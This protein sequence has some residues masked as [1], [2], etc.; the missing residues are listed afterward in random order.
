MKRLKVGIIGCGEV[1]Q[2]MH[3]PALTALPELFEVTAICDVSPGVLAGVGD[4]WRIAGRYTEHEALLAESGVDAV[5]I[6][7]P[8]VF[9]AEVAAAAMQAGKHV[10]IEKPMC[11]TL[12]EADTLIAAR[13][14]YGVVAQVGYMRRYDSGFLA[15]SEQVRAIGSV[16]MARIR[17]VIGRNA[18]IVNATSD[19]VRASD[20][21]EGS[22]QRLQARQREAVTAAI[23]PVSND[24]AATYVR[25][26]GL[27]SHD[28]SAMREMLGRP[29]GLFY[30]VARHS[31][32]ALSAAF[33]YGSFVC[34]MEIG[35]DEIARMDSHIEI[36][37]ETTVL[38]LDY[39]TPYIRFQPSRLAVTTAHDKSGLATTSIV[40]SRADAFMSEWRAFHDNVVQ[41]RV[42]KTS[43]EDG[44]EDI[45]LFVEMVRLMGTTERQS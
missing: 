15:A 10:L 6:A 27:A 19:V 21:P 25:L 42:P 43:L 9:H 18:L 14:R 34:H 35:I 20:L 8:H 26:L 24:L 28:T 12:A 36:R 39:D 16:H 5:L 23:G 2:I 44:R 37:S 31:G 40:P 38:R 32:R 3:L 33:D 4:R 11:L 7:N 13:E 45:A 29:Q 41:N 22:G 17:D 30:A 1:T